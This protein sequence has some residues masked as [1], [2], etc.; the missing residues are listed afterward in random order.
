MAPPSQ[1]FHPWIKELEGNTMPTT[2]KVAPTRV[3]VAKAFPQ[4]PTSA[5][6]GPRSQTLSIQHLQRRC[7][8]AP[9]KPL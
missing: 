5:N 6:V 4:D 9:W 7:P 2:G 3:A 1:G 8:V